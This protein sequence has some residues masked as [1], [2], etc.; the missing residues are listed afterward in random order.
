MTETK[1]RQLLADV[2]VEIVHKN[3]RGWLVASCPFAEYLHEYGTDREP[4]FMVKIN[5]EGYSGINCFTCHQ[6][7]NLT[8]FLTKLGSLRGEDYDH[9]VIRAMTQETPES[10]KDWDEAR[11]E[12]DIPQEIDPLDAELYLRMY[13]LAWEDERSRKYL[14][15]RDVSAEAAHDLDLRFDPD[16]RRIL[17]PVYDFEKKLFGFTGRTILP[18]S[19]L[20][21]KHPKVKDYAGLRKELCLLGEH[22]IDDDKPILVVEGLFAL[23][24]MITIGAREFCNPVATMGSYL[25]DHQR[26]ILV[27]RGLPVY[28]LYDNDKAGDEGLF[29][30]EGDPDSVGAL[31]KMKA[32]VP[33][34]VCL[35]PSSINDP[36]NLNRNHVYAMVCEDES[37]PA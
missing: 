33:T 16:N 8:K 17:F 29:G 36:D 7:G 18:P 23:A 37:D 27:D 34:F 25:S 15:G 35:Y 14:L 3:S 21:R 31:D 12:R 13:P 19:R 32:H 5:D 2:D 28:F 20:S 26:D 11:A 22:L 24:R 4:S 9:L 10:F 1:L 6:K 30:I